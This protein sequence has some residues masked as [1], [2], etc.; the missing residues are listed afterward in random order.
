MEELLDILT[1]TDIDG[2]GATLNF[3][4]RRIQPCN[5][6]VHPTYEY[7]DEDFAREAPE[8]LMNEKIGEWASKFFMANTMLGNRHQQRPYSFSH[9]CLQVSG[10]N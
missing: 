5:E 7:R 6:R 2:V 1:H 4:G 8:K 9:P 3:I 10:P